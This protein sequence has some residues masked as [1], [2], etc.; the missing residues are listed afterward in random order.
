MWLSHRM[1]LSH[2]TQRV[3]P[4]C[5]RREGGKEGRKVRTNRKETNGNCPPTR[6]CLPDQ[7]PSE[8][9]RAD[10]EVYIYPPPVSLPL[11]LFFSFFLQ[12]HESEIRYVPTMPSTFALFSITVTIKLRLSFHFT[13]LS[14]FL[15]FS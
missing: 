13:F 3:L 10:P 4:L 12:P 14:P 7:S 11:F 9:I 5:V 6:S 15:A 8:V 1:W 2:L